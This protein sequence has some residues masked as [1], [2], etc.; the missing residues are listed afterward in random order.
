MGKPGMTYEKAGVNISAGNYYARLIKERIDKAWPDFADQIGGFAG[1]GPI[2]ANAT[3]VKGCTDG[4]GTKPKLAALADMLEV[5]GQDAVA[6]SA[7][8][9]YVAGAFPAYLLDTISIG[10]LRPEYHIRIIDGIIAGC[11]AAGS[12]LIGGE[13]AELPGIF[14]YPWMFLVDTA[15]IAFPSPEL[16]YAPMKAG[17]KVYGW[18]S[19][20][21]AAN[22]LS[23]M[24]RGFKLDGSDSVSWIRRLFGADEDPDVAR[25][26]LQQSWPELG[27]QTLAQAILQPTPIYIQQIEAERQAGVKFSGHAHITGGGLVENIPRILP[28]DLK[29]VIHRKTWNRPPIFP[30]IQR[31]GNVPPDDMDRTFNQGVMMVSVVSDEGEPLS[32]GK[33]GPDK[34]S[35]IGEVMPRDGIEA[36]VELLGSYADLNVREI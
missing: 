7:V 16:A 2:P 18:M 3:G 22:G 19:G 10:H 1:G 24:R 27:G 32:T 15:V 12:I 28:P 4:A 8:D 17:Q 6:M 33:I 36:Q 30:L 35:L 9:A 23:L 21:P 26:R 11:K 20:S 25:K 5:V 31:V 14:K 29:V 13:T 34:I